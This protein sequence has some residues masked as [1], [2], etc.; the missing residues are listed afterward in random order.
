MRIELRS[1][2]LYSKHSRD[3]T[4][5]PAL[6][7]YIFTY[8]FFYSSLFFFPSGLYRFMENMPMLQKPNTY[9][10]QFPMTPY[11]VLRRKQKEVL[12]KTY[13][14]KISRTHFSYV[15]CWLCDASP[16]RE[17]CR[18]LR[19][20]DSGRMPSFLRPCQLHQ[21]KPEMQILWWLTERKAVKRDKN[22][23]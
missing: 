21:H 2:C 17:R 1:A 13:L 19:A 9:C 14:W 7:F 23:S 4:L 3:W 20:M 12:P 15:A 5:I 18:V 10:F 11:Q 6:T 16:V 8:Y 22:G